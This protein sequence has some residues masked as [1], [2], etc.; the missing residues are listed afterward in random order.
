M[1]RRAG[2]YVKR[3]GQLIC[4]E[5][6]LGA[7]LTEALEKVGYL[8]PSEKQFWKWLD[9]NEE[10]RQQYERA[11]QLQADKLAD[12]HLTLAKEVLK[13]DGKQAPKYKVA[14]DV[15]KWQAE[16]R[17]RG[18]Y[19]PKAEPLGKKDLKPEEI[20]AEI[21]RLEKELGIRE[22]ENVVPLHGVKKNG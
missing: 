1:T 18:K 6:A 12:E 19:G 16:I 21:K 20:K 10:F 7:T 5:I 22:G 13:V 14:A 8:A 3:T 15:L 4:E 9:Q 2:H 17:N 11:R